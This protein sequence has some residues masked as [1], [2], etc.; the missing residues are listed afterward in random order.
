MSTKDCNNQGNPTEDYISAGNNP[1][2]TEADTNSQPEVASIPIKETVFKIKSTKPVRNTQKKQLPSHVTMRRAS[3]I[4][5]C[6]MTVHLNGIV[7][8]ALFDTGATRCLLSHSVYEAMPDNVKRTIAYD[9]APQLRGIG[10]LLVNT[11]GTMPVDV[12][13]ADRTYPIDMIVQTGDEITGCIL[14][15]DFFEKYGCSLSMK[16]GTFEIEGIKLKWEAELSHDMC[17]RVR[18]E[19]STIV[20]ARSEIIVSGKADAKIRYFPGVQCSSEPAYYAQELAVDGVT[21]GGSLFLSGVTH[22]PI[23]IVNPTNK[24][25]HI[26]KG[27]VI[28]VALPVDH[29][30]PYEQTPLGQKHNGNDR[31]RAHN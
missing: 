1:I 8:R 4:N 9:N 24:P 7:T 19:E 11:M 3:K 2:C 17:A 29:S 16:D 18:V 23:P 25:V 5:G 12:I 30:L 22:I 31:L 27:C 20:P 15:L 6:V 14:G 26:R 13:M 10:G 28:A 21:V